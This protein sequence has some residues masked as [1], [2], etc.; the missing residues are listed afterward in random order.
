MMLAILE[1]ADPTL[2]TMGMS[3]SA[4]MVWYGIRKQECVPR[5]LLRVL[6]VFLIMYVRFV[7]QDIWL[8][9]QID[10]Q[11]LEQSVFHPAQR[12]SPK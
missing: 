12:V 9:V 8:I 10:L 6:H 5:V 2:R 1:P 11:T 3:V 4:F 7:Q